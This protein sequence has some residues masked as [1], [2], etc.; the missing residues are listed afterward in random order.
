[1][2]ALFLLFAAALFGYATAVCPPPANADTINLIERFEGFVPSP[3][4]DPIG[5]PTVGYGHL[6]K[7]KGCS[8]VPFKFPVTKANAVTLLHSD[9]TTF[10]NCV[11]SD[12]KRSVHLNDN[13]YGALVSWAYN[14]GCGNIKTSSLVRRL[15]AGEDP[16]TV[17]A[18]E[19]PQWNKGGGKVLPG[20]VRRRAEEVKLFKTPSSVSAHPC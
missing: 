2:K 3:R 20:L 19:L 5:L 12:I 16:N 4:P 17:A 1:M 13:Q 11:N 10:Q 7:T 6:C 15:N 9:L 18:Q 8:E 14:V